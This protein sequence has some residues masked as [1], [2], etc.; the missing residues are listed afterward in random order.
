M[1][2]PQPLIEFPLEASYSVL[3]RMSLDGVEYNEGDVLTP[4]LLDRYF[5]PA[6]M[7]NGAR[8]VHLLC[9]QRRLGLQTA[10]ARA[11]S[12]GHATKK[13]AAPVVTKATAQSLDLD[14]M[15]VATLKAKCQEL[16]LSPYG[17]K[18]QLRNRLRT[19]LG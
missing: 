16:G 12:E 6:V 4:E 2:Q 14:T 5:G 10:S 19:K 8:R 11:T 13:S 17:N 3:T 15:D 1:P 18:N 9:E 7:A